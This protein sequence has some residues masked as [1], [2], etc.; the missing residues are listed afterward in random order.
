MSFR[1]PVGA[2][3]DVKELQ[4][5][6]ALHQTCLPVC[7]ENATVS[8]I[9]VVRLLRSRFGL[10]VSHEDAI[11]VVRG[12]GGGTMTEEVLEKILEQIYTDEEEEEEQAGK[13]KRKLWPGMLMKRLKKAQSVKEIQDENGEEEIPAQDDEEQ[14]DD[15]EGSKDLSEE[16]LDLVQLLAI[17]LIPTLAKAGKEFKDGI[18]N[19]VLEEDN[20]EQDESTTEE[21]P[22]LN[23]IKIYKKHNA[24]SQAK[25]K[26]MER[27]ERESLRPKPEG[28]IGDVRH[29]LLGN[30]YN[31]ATN[32]E[33]VSIEMNEEGPTL[34]AD[35]VTSLLG[36]W[37]EHERAKDSKLVD[38]MVMVAGGP[39]TPFNEEAFV[40]ALTSDL[41]KWEVGTEDRLSTSF[42][43]VWNYDSRREKELLD[44]EQAEAKSSAIDK[45]T[46]QQGEILTENEEEEYVPRLPLMGANID[47]AVD[48]HSSVAVTCILWLFFVCTALVYAVLFQSTDATK[49]SCPRS[50][51]CTLGGT[52]WRWLALAIILSITG[53]LVIVPLSLSNTPV[54][55]RPRI[56]VMCFFIAATYTYLPYIIVLDYRNDSEPPYN[57]PEKVVNDDRYDNTQV[58][59]FAVG[60]ALL[61]LYMIQFVLSLKSS[62]SLQQRSVATKKFFAS[63]NVRGGFRIKKAATRKLNAMLSNAH[64]LHPEGRATRSK[65]VL[66]S[67]RG[68][69]SSDQTMLN[70]VLNGERQEDCGGLVWTWKKIFTT[71]L[72]DTEGVWI[73]SRI[74]VFQTAQFI[75][76]LSVSGTAFYLTE[77]IA[78]LADDAT[79]ELEDLDIGELTRMS[80]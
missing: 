65:S 47:F 80:E 54:T 48:C 4:Y 45:A 20:C 57:D 22:S 11:R 40:N 33:S 29:M 24:E 30:L 12:L 60:N 8:S 53:L 3:V 62:R 17:M 70:Y 68:S 39:G 55:S 75:L 77:Y 2:S 34:S 64:S 14:H 13:Q 59:T 27:E 28:V 19:E 50:F 58:I 42:F 66:S 63:S 56:I 71:E 16:Y 49:T 18:N 78:D 26:E 36:A 15:I 52:V 73:N 25:Q 74:W 37:G 46:A 32:D 31:K 61:L 10:K 67:L 38:A 76:G 51:G 23:P 44:K 43:D 21:G 72:F 1:R 6:A 41:S 9:D 69:S 79:Q 5:I 7:R 35:L